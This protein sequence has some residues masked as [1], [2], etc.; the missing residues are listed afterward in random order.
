MGN[1]THESYIHGGNVTSDSADEPY[2]HSGNTVLTSTKEP[3]IRDVDAMTDSIAETGKTHKIL[4]NIL[5]P[6]IIDSDNIGTNITLRGGFWR[7]E[8][9]SA[10][11][12]KP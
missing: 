12:P 4:L 1:F 11:L 9:V 3:D 2:I 10:C 7:H 5:G 6:N 8:C